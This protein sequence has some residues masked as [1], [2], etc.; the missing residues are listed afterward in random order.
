MV[1]I[2]G[3]TSIWDT[4]LGAQPDPP[5]LLVLLTGV[6]ALVVVSTGRLWRVARNAVT[7]AHE[8]G[9]ALAALLTGRRL[10]GIRLHSDTSGLTLS[11]GRPTGLGM[12]I[13]LLAGYLAPPL[14]GLAGAGILGG[15][16]ITLLLWVAVALLLAMLV[17][18][19]NVFGALSLLVTG[20]LVLAV[21]WY[22]A[23]Q[24]QAAFAYTGVW[25]LLLG[26]LRPVVE[27]Q[28][29]R[30]RGRMPA[31]DADQLAGITPFPAFF[32]VSVFALVNLAVLGFGAVLLAGRILTGHGLSG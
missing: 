29:L 12:V 2:D 24:V 8:G 6:G 28:R 16:R 11:A 23:P 9:H 14:V 4:L 22:A 3:L 10:H 5:P 25:F 20:G 32:W 18:I 13:T 15:N 26:G 17:L 21:S 27:L 1:S 30:A 7:I 31:S 19:R